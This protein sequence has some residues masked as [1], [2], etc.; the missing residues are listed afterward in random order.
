MKCFISQVSLIILNANE[1]LHKP[2]TLLCDQCPN[3]G[4][5]INA[6]LNWDL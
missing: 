2:D 1:Q 5:K 6:N 3:D 4:A